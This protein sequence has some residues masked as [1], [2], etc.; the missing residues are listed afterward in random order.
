[1]QHSGDKYKDESGSNMERTK[2]Y[3]S[4]C[5]EVGPTGAENLS[6]HGMSG[7]LNESEHERA[8]ERGRESCVSVEAESHTFTPK[9]SEEAAKQEELLKASV[10]FKLRS[11]C[12]LLCVK[13]RYFVVDQCDNCFRPDAFCSKI[14]K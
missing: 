9:F 8:Y 7:V 3:K 14:L 2:L 4:C 5:F 12:L 11:C 13:S 1:M 10:A 6:A